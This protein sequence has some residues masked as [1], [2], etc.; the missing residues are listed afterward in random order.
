M[1]LIT[2]LPDG[3]TL[4]VPA[5]TRLLAAVLRAG[6][7]IGY[8]CRGLGVCVACRLRVEGDAAPPDERE[9]ALLARIAE[10]GP[11]RI[12]CLARIDGDVTVRA[13]YW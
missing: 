1:P 7:P 6:R 13:D 12:A 4:E 8:S 10:P 11:W 5:G 3:A 2:F 9:R